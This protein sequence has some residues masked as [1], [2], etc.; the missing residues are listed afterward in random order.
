MSHTGTLPRDFRHSSAPSPSLT[1]STPVRPEWEIFPVQPLYSRGSTPGYPLG[2]SLS[3]PGYPKYHG[4]PLGRRPEV[5]FNIFII[6]TTTKTI[7]T[8]KKTNFAI[9]TTKSNSLRCTLPT[10]RLG[11]YLRSGRREGVT[12][13]LNTVREQYKLSSCSIR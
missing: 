11:L 5:Q 10:T 1:H 2:G 12:L 13:G 8:I 9:N 3:T 6:T 7:Q 4:L